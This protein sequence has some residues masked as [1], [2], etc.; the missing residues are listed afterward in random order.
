MHVF[1]KIRVKA[2]SPYAVFVE[3]SYEHN[4][5]EGT[6]TY[7]TRRRISKDGEGLG[8]DSRAVVIVAQTTSGEY[9]LNKEFRVP[10]SGY[11]LSF[12][13]GLIDEGETPEQAAVRELSEETP[14]RVI[15]VDHVSP[16]LASSPGI[17]DEMIYMVRCT[18]EPDPEGHSRGVSEDIETFL[19]KDLNDDRIPTGPDVSWGVK[20][21]LE[22][23]HRTMVRSGGYAPG[24]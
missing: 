22:L 4:G 23:Y 1:P 19:V 21:W 2:T 5:S 12:P 24:G 9:L 6:W 8:K 17:T 18:V 3:K 16:T 7:I 13:A 15:S 20:A 10:L 14:F 11:N